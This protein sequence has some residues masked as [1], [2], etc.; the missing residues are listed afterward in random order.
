MLTSLTP[1]PF[2]QSPT[3][4]SKTTKP[5]KERED[6]S[7]KR[8]NLTRSGK[9]RVYAVYVSVNVSHADDVVDGLG[10]V[11]Q[12]V[13]HRKSAECLGVAENDLSMA[14]T[15]KG[16][17]EKSVV[18]EEVGF[19]CRKVVFCGQDDNY[20]FFLSLDGIDGRQL[21]AEIRTVRS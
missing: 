10:T 9:A 17:I 6:E 12:L 11:E 8:K 13:P 20:L 16:D 3:R 18:V 2:T 1:P 5:T 14:A 4:T 15:R 7:E 19:V 21:D